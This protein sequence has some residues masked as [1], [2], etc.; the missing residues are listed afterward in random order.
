MMNLRLRSVGIGLLAIAG[1]M[2]LD[3]ITPVAADPGGDDDDDITIG[4]DADLNYVLFRDDKT[5]SMSGKLSDIERARR[6]KQPSER[7]LWF[8]DGGHEYVVRD[9]ATLKEIET[10]WRPVNE[11]GEAQGKLGSQVGELGRKMGELGSQQ[12]LLGTR[13]GTLSTREATL[14]IR[15][16]NDSL[17]DAQRADLAR[18]RAALKQQIREL[19]KQ[20]R[21][22]E[23]PMRELEARM[24]PLN[25][26]MEVLGKK[27]EGLAHKAKG[28]M[29][30]VLR[31][32]IASGVAKQVK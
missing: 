8:R 3:P 18:R 13:Q 14:S 24:E 20:M 6:Y 23:K 9:P 16:S 29:R 31:R 11:L 4:G 21:A 2:G 17:S 32:T 28:E 26:E 10:L 25:R 1:L 19:D 12:G 5:T 30:T 27:M 15:E 22:L 7:I